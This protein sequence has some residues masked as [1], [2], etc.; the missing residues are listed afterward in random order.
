[1]KVKALFFMFVYYLHF[2][3][4]LCNMEAAEGQK[5]LF[6]RKK[7]PLGS[8][9]NPESASKKGFTTNSGQLS[10]IRP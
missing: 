6:F 5:A 3:V 2:Q 4:A 8:P 10:S 7:A 9:N 1:M